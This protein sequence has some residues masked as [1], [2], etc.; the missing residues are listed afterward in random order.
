MGFQK[1]FIYKTPFEIAFMFNRSKVGR[2]LRK[3]G[4]EVST[5]YLKQLTSE[6]KQA[7]SKFGV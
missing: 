4:G 2:V 7:L 5:D 1:V 6:E 3:A